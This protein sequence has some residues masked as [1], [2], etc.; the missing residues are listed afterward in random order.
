MEFPGAPLTEGTN[1]DTCDR[2]SE[3][4]SVLSACIARGPHPPGPPVPL[5]SHL[6]EEGAEGPSDQLRA[7]P[8]TLLCQP[9]PHRVRDAPHVDACLSAA[10]M[11]ATITRR[12]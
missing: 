9:P 12:L 7:Q 6:G 4:P 2:V 5:P 1:G 10:T 11:T 8:T 3:P